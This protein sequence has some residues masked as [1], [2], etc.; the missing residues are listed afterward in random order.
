M[1]D[2]AK[3]TLTSFVM[4]QLVKNWPNLRPNPLLHRLLQIDPPD[5]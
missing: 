2:S 3:A 4:R 5:G 1:T